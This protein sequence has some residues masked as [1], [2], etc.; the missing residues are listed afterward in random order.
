M[1]DQMTLQTIGILL[2]GLTVSIAAIYYTMTLRYTRRNQELQLETRQ[3]QLF[4]QVYNRWCD[5]SFAKQYSLARYRYTQDIDELLKAVFDPYDP[6]IHIPFHVLGQFFE[7]IGM[8]VLND[9]VDFNLVEDLLSTRIIWYWERMRPWYT[10]ERGIT[11]DPDLYKG[12]EHLYDE[13]M[14]RR[15]QRG[16][17]TVVPDTYVEHIREQGESKN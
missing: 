1:V 9:L 5:P 13:M 17:T 4:M 10:R 6:E 15:E 8:L 16:V 3:A 12:M 14:K 2:T 7:G 11:G